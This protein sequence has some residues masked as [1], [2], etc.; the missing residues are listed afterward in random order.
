[1]VPLFVSEKFRGKTER[2]LYGDVIAEI[3]WSVGEILAALKKHGIDRKTLVIYISDNGPWLSYGDHGGSARPLREGKGTSWEGGI[4]V[5]CIM[6]W[7]ERIPAGSVSSEPVMTIDILPT[8]A[9]LVGGRLPPHKIDGKDL[10]PLLVGSS[11]AKSPH[12]A[13][14]IYY[15][16]NELQ[17]LLSGRWKLYLPHTYRTLAGRPGGEGGKPVPYRRARTKTALYDLQ[18]DVAETTEIADRYP[19]VVK[20][21]LGLAE[22]CRDDLGDALT[23]RPAQGARPPGKL[24]SPGRPAPGP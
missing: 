9:A 19:E 20:R 1:H 17:A 16:R 12:D 8:L 10:G 24:P 5:P 15:R 7:P 3:D 22:K 23:G 2:G 18:A 11:G 13:Y 14:F 4:R 6:R 21:L